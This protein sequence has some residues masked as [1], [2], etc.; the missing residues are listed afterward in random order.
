MQTRTFILVEMVIVLLCLPLIVGYTAP[1]YESVEL[2]LQPDYTAPAYDAVELI[3]NEVVEAAPTDSCT[4]VSG[5]WAITLEDNCTLVTTDIHP[6]NITITGAAGTLTIP[7]G[8]VI[9][10]KNIAFTPDDFDGDARFV[11]EIG[12]RRIIKP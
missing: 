6:N 10:A 2:V 3:L 8:V 1:S 12:G 7:S 4:Y 5:D 9:T 11:I